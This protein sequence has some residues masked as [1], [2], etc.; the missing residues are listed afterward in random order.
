MRRL[1][2]VL[3]AAA[4]VLA[5]VGA[6]TVA[7][8]GT[9]AARLGVVSQ[10][11]NVAPLAPIDVVLHVPGAIDLATIPDATLV[12]T[13]YRA[14][15]S[16]EAVSQVLKGDLPRSVDSLDL[17]LASLGRPA[18]DQ[19]QASIPTETDRTQTALQLPRE[20][21]Y[22]LVVELRNDGEVLA[23]LTT[24]VQQVPGPGEPEPDPLP[25]AFAVSTT[26]PV[27]LDDRLKVVVDSTTI[28]D[29]ESLA[30]VLEASAIP[31]AVRVPP[32]LLD[33]IAADPQYAQLAARLSTDLTNE[34][35]LSSPSW[36]LDP[37]AAAAAGAEQLYTQWLR[38]GE[39]V[40]A[41]VVPNPS[42]RTV[43]FGDEP[44]SEAGG[45]ML[46]DLCARLLV[47]TTEQ[48]DQLPDTLGGFTETSH[49]VRIDVGGGATLDATVIDR[50]ASERLARPTTE[51]QLNA[52]IT[53]AHLV[54]YREEIEVDGGDPQRRGVSLATPELGLPPLETVRA[55]TSLIATTPGL[56]GT[57]FNELS[58][59]ADPMLLDGDEVVV[60]LPD[61]VPGDISGRI[62]TVNALTLESLSTGS[63]LPEGDPRIAAWQQ[64][65]GILP[66]S[67]LTDVQVATIAADLRDEFTAIRDAVV[68]PDGFSFTLTGRRT[69]I[70]ITLQNTSATPLTVVV[71]MSSTKLLFPDGDQTVTLA[72][73][74]FTEITVPIEARASGRSPVTLEVLT[75][76]GASRIGPAVPLTAS[77]TA[78]GGLGIL[79]TGAFILVVLTW[80]V[81]HVRRNRRARAAGGVVTRH[82]AAAAAATDG[83][84]PQGEAPTAT[85]EPA[86]API[87]DSGLSP[88]AAT[89]TLPPS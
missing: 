80:W 59:R 37:S 16:R 76:V 83:E 32:A 53:V 27:V 44:L 71:R 64:R 58:F 38:D 82:P 26:T 21:L 11:F 84:Y 57:T 88:D 65:I 85:D 3:A 81:R 8:A 7:H 78:I 25:I 56:S 69:T 52:I 40:L 46:R 2:R 29:L 67:A 68:L 36:P 1:A 63:M 50:T 39:D 28:R 23:D 42:V 89:S 15:E 62:T 55:L 66:T 54:A 45:A 20:G 74:S 48:Y 9:A 79:V 10:T 47:L 6:P 4:A 22:P 41:G 43:V 51:P 19:L 30:D 31:V 73:Q 49:L 35:L 18:A 17:P 87:D 5:T 60:G 77:V 33:A 75:P 86:T 12:V 14:V 70:P 61:S 13:S 72:P 24:F 34:E